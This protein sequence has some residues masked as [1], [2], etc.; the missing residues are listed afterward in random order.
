MRRHSYSVLYSKQ[1]ATPK[2]LP[3]CIHNGVLIFSL[4]ELASISLP[5]SMAKSKYTPKNKSRSRTGPSFG[6]MKVK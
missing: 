1:M 4:S 3:N 6:I 5:A 2:L